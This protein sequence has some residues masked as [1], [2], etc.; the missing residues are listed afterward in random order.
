LYPEIIEARFQSRIN[1]FVVLCEFDGASQLAHLPNPGR[2]WELLFPGTLLY[3]VPSAGKAKKTGFKVIGIE[4]E[5]VPVML[6]THY[7]NLVAETLIDRQCIPQLAGWRVLR[8]E[9]PF[10]HSRF[11]LLLGKGEEQFILEVKSCT[12]FGRSLAMFP[13]AVTERGRRH[14]LELA[15]LADEG[16]RVGVLFLVQWDRA[17]YFLPDYHTDLEFA[18]TFLSLH[19]KVMFMAVAINWQKDFSLPGQVRSL[20]IPWDV[21]EREVRD[22]GCY[23]FVIRLLADRD[24]LIGSK[25]LLRFKQGYYI[26]VGSAKANL[27]KRMARHQRKRKK[28][29]WHIDYLREHSEFHAAIPIRSSE[30]LEHELARGISDIADWQVDGFGCSDCHCASHLFGMAEDPL[31]LPP[32]MKL[33]QYFRMDRLTEE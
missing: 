18:R 30:N 28:Y 4:R 25:G 16:Y 26:Y 17:A 1:R 32:F 24:I 23:L 31:H 9:V 10:G 6:D 3:L 33:V 15:R 7:S 2:M 19:H 22:S 21:L 11:D 8:R 12:L 14:M 13:D 5:G 20:T 29:H 27:A